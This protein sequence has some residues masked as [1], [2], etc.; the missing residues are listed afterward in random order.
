M[1]EL[2]R[3]QKN[4]NGELPKGI[5][6]I[7]EISGLE[8]PEE[9]L[10]ICKSVIITF[11]ENQSLKSEDPKWKN[12]MPKKII[13][14]IDQLD[15]EDYSN[16]E[17]LFPLELLIYD[18]KE[19]KDWEWFSSKLFENKIQL[20]FKKTFYPKFYWIVHCQNIPLSQMFFQDD[21]FGNYVPKVYKDVTSYKKF[22]PLE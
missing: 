19:Y 9:V 11:L 21:R 13:N 20:V 6:T 8:N 18:L 4:N 14:F 2:V 3:I 15:D 7:L 5:K 1:T 12:L 22:T 17:Y 16:D 10:S